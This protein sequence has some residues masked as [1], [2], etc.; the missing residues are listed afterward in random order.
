M[1]MGLLTFN[2]CGDDE[3]EKNVENVDGSGTG[4]G[5]TDNDKV[6][7]GND[8]SGNDNSGNGT[9]D[10]SNNALPASEQQAKL[11]SIGQEAL[12]CVSAKDFQYWK[13]L[14]DHLNREYLDNDDMDNDAIEDFFED[15]V[16]SSHLGSNSKKEEGYWTYV[17]EYDNYRQLVN[18]SNLKAR[19]VAGS[20]KWTK[21][22]ADHLEFV[23]K[24]QNGSQVELCLTT[25]GNTKTVHVIDEEHL[26]EYWPGDETG[27]ETEFIDRDRY[28]VTIP[29]N[30]T[31]SVKV[32]GRERMKTNVN[33]KLDGIQNEIADLS[34]TIF[35]ASA[36]VTLD[37]YVFKTTNTKYVPNNTLQTVFSMA[38]DGKSILTV[39]FNVGDF[40]L[41]NISGDVADKDTWETIGEGTEITNGKAS[42]RLNLLGKLQINGV[43]DDIHSFVEAMEDADK[44][45][46]EN[47]MK[48]KQCIDN[49]NK[50]ATVGVYYDGKPEKQAEFLFKAFEQKSWNGTYWDAE[51]VLAFADGSSYSLLEESDFFN[52][53]SFKKL[54]DQLENLCEDFDALF[55]Y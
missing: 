19:F 54:I 31:I 37:S 40:K 7:G 50:I 23:V 17:Y 9:G 42:F 4:T 35:D 44:Y 30:I 25:S 36:T 5:T 49:I 45:N 29:E 55:G 48:F 12:S 41:S 18:L 52:E 28:Y 53:S 43:V 26:Q 24:D 20:K 10:I 13:D 15:F 33:I 22:N 14:A 34:K 39:E 38:K 6:P 21:E 16:E 27:V 8:N 11:Q 32:G 51:P 2:A 1:A 47:E 3:P 46:E